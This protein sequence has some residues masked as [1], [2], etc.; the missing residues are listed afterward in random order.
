M[1][2]QRKA[3]IEK[4]KKKALTDTIMFTQCNYCFPIVM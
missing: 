4:K 2:E 1:E 3:E